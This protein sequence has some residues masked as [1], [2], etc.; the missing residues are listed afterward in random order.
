M[1]FLWTAVALIAVAILAA[2]RF[3]IGRVKTQI[4]WGSRV[5]RSHRLD[6]IA[7]SHRARVAALCECDALDDRTWS[8]LNCDDVFISIDRTES[9]LGQHALYHRL[10]TQ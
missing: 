7:E 3:G 10:R 1:S 2:R 8:D 9:T 6:V 4:F 5:E